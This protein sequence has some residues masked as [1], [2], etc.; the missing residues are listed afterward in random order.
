MEE[1]V[2]R[3]KEGF[4]PQAGCQMEHCAKVE[5]SWWDFCRERKCRGVDLF[6]YLPHMHNAGSV[7]IPCP[8][9]LSS[10]HIL[11]SLH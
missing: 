10:G 8:M 5:E 1:K 4:L 9:G 7:R 3:Q 11:H 6:P 2:T